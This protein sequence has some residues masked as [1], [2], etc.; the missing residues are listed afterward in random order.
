MA[1]APARVSQLVLDLVGLII[2]VNAT[3]VNAFVRAGDG[4]V[5]CAATGSPAR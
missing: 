3:V 4:G 1:A 5:I 2:L